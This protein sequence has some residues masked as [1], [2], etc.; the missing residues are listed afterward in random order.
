[1]KLNNNTLVVGYEHSGMFP[2]G[3]KTKERQCLL[4]ADALPTKKKRGGG[5]LSVT[6]SSDRLEQAFRLCYRLSPAGVSVGS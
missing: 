2:L 5:H 4:S 3:R 1:M 6:A